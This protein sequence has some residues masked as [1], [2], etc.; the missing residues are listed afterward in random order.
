MWRLMTARTTS[1]YPT[2]WRLTLD[3]VFAWMQHGR[4]TMVPLTRVY[5]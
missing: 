2:A 4:L 1:G 3:F 5:L